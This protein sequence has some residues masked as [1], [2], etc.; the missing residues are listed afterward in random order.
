ME[1]G[2]M[3]Y[4]DGASLDGLQQVV[5]RLA[6]RLGR[7]AA[8]DD[9]QGRLVVASQHFGEEDPIRVY[10][11][12][13]RV[14]DPRVMEHFRATGI[15]DWTEPGRV[16][17]NPD[18]DFKPRIAVPIRDHDIL[19]GHLFLIDEGV[20][21]W[22]IEE[23]VAAVGEIGQL[24]Y[25]R[26]VLHEEAMSRSET[27]ARDLVSGDAMAQA[28][29]LQQVTDE[30]LVVTP[31]PALALLVRASGDQTAV[32]VALR[33]AAERVTRD[34]QRNASLASVR[35]SEPVVLLF[36]RA[37]DPA[38]GRA[39]ADSFV[40]TT[41]EQP[42]VEGAAAGIGSVRSGAVACAASYDDAVLAA[43]AAAVLP[44]FGAVVGVDELGVYGLLMRLPE[45]ELHERHYPAGLRELLAAD[46]KDSL[47]ETLETYLDSS[48]DA[49]LTAKELHVHR[50]T[51][52]YRLGRIESI[53]GVNLRDGADRL[54]MH[55]GLKLRH[56]VEAGGSSGGSSGRD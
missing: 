36:G 28:L 23:A 16:P 7:S 56:L 49:T 25:R 55:V 13:H 41:G 14:S 9:V 20:E 33:T 32:E 5:D 12:I 27:V 51:L 52:Y 6:N 15:Y 42:G 2:H 17:A 19:F 4:S 22:E 40:A 53:A 11:I 34:R 45:E 3:Q 8:I 24:M 35:G 1:G 50:S 47:V 37:A 38:Q 48:G 54:S 44:Q 26:L 21:E 46:G 10:A 29:A 18:F 39:V 30:Q 43:R 31:D